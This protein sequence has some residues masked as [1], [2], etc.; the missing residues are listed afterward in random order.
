[1]RKFKYS[2]L[3]LLLAVDSQGFSRSLAKVSVFGKYQGYSE[4]DYDGW[5]KTSRFLYM[6]DK[7]QLAA[8]IIRPTRMGKV[9]EQPLPVVFMH[10]RYHRDKGDASPEFCKHLLQHGYVL[11]SVDTRGSGASFGTSRGVFAPEEALDSFEI[12]EWIAKQPW[13]NGKIGMQGV[14]YLGGVQLMAASMRPPHL[15]AIFP[16]MTPSDVYGLAYHNGVFFQNLIKRWFAV[17]RLLDTEILGPSVDDDVNGSLLKTAVKEHFGNRSVLDIFEANPFR[18]SRDSLTGAMIARDWQ[19]SGCF[20]KIQEAQIP[21]Y[22]WGGWFDGFVRDAFLIHRNTGAS[23]KLVVGAWSHSPRDPEISREMFELLKVEELR[24]F[25]YWL[26]GID[27]GIG[28]EP[29]IRYNTMKN[30][31]S[32]EWRTTTVWPLPNAKATE[33][34]FKAGPIGSVGSINDGLLDASVPTVNQEQDE[35]VVNY[36]ATTGTTSR[37][38]NVVGEGFGYPSMTGNDQKGLTYTTRILSGDMEVS[39]HPVVCLW[40]ASS[41]DDAE[42]FVYLE[43]VQPDGR[44]SYITEGA[45]KASYR[46]LSQAPYHFLDLPYHSECKADFKPLIPG[47]PTE[48]I[49]DLLPTSYIFK[50]GNRIRLTI[51]CADRDNSPIKELTPPPSITLFRGGTLCSKLI[52]PL[53]A[54]QGSPGLEPALANNVK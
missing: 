23:N 25:D 20:Q 34:F 40:A 28:S 31:K 10:A 5:V 6:S 16:I 38:C 54:Q 4:A 18:D 14:S 39:G 19:P 45:L 42:F 37:W 22:L 53:L 30:G 11:V 2:L 48:L 13:C 9:E 29:P 35:Y 24:W 1:M 52:L 8:D 47:Q 7:V 17:T 26:K 32:N 50:A 21:I 15:K 51:T 49:F 43:D 27:N 33:F 36:T 41:V 12:I 46:A 44:S 3:V